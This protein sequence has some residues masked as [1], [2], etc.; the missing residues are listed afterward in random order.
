MDAAFNQMGR[1]IRYA[2][3]SNART[4]RLAILMMLIAVI[5]WLVMLHAA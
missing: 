3:G 1:T 2:V 5:Y 4:A